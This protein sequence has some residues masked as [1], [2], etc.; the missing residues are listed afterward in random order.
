MVERHSLVFTDL[1]GS[2]SDETSRY[3]TQHANLISTL[4]ER[5]ET[6]KSS[7]SLSSTVELRIRPLAEGKENGNLTNGDPQIALHATICNTKSDGKC[8]DHNIATASISHCVS[9]E[10]DCVNVTSSNQMFLF[11][12][13]ELI[14][15][16]NAVQVFVTRAGGTSDLGVKEAEEEYLTS[17]KGI[18]ARDLPPLELQS[19]ATNA[20]SQINDMIVNGWFK[21]VLASPG[22]AKP[23]Y[24]VRL[25][26]RL[27]PTDENAIIRTLKVKCRL[28]DAVPTSNGTAFQHS[29]TQ[30]PEMDPPICTRNLD[31]L[32][33]MMAIMGNTRLMT[34]ASKPQNI[35][36]V[37]PSLLT[38]ME[39]TNSLTSLMPTLANKTTWT[40]TAS[41]QN[42]G[43]SIYFETQQRQEKYQCEIM[44]S[45][46]GLG[47]FLKSS[48][49]KR[50]NSFETTLM[51]MESRIMQK[52][53][54]LSNRL[55]AIENQISS[56]ASLRN[57]NDSNA[58][59]CSDDAYHTKNDPND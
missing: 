20:G 4:F 46:A 3:S 6:K 7:F 37:V 5:E 39:D 40:N 34:N 24:S 27:S 22:G 28:N 48:E 23:V 13:F 25:E 31:N 33:S 10:E 2:C 55:S 50:R 19:Q 45:I 44:S 54:T 36:R 11:G 8:R 21:F 56:V 35:E 42:T 52:L 58:E 57:G 53:D 9:V 18:P 30:S 41:T 59:L 47:M 14:A 12:G 16:I 17:C 51:Q 43:P 26:F 32:A 38:R 49:E 1:F 29:T 15:S